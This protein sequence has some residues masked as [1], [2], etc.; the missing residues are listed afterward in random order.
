MWDD[1]KLDDHVQ[2]VHTTSASTPT[3]TGPV[4][5]AEPT[6]PTTACNTTTP[7]KDGETTPPNVPPPGTSIEVYWDEEKVWYPCIIKDAGPDTDG[8]WVSLC[9]YDD[10][11]KIWHN[12]QD[13]VHRLLTATVVRLEKLTCGTLRSILIKAGVSCSRLNKSSL[14]QT[15]CRSLTAPPTT[16][17]PDSPTE[18][19]TTPQP[20]SPTEETTTTP[21]PDS[22][23]DE[24]TTSPKPDTPNVPPPGTSIEVYWDEDEVWYPCI[25]KAA[26]TDTDGSWVSLCAYDDGAK[27]WHNLQ[28]H[29]HRS[30]TPT[31]TRVGKL[32][33]GELRR[34]L[35]QARVTFQ[36]E[37]RKA[38]LI[39]TLFEYLCQQHHDNAVDIGGATPATTDAVVV[40]GG[41]TPATTDAVVVTPAT[42]D[43][44]VVTGG[45]TP[46]STDVVV[47]TGG[48]TPATTD[49]VVVTGGA[50]R[51]TTTENVETVSELLHVRAKLGQTH[52]ARMKLQQNQREVDEAPVRQELP[53]E[54]TCAPNPYL[55]ATQTCQRIWEHAEALRV[56]TTRGDA[57]SY[58]ER[59]EYNFITIKQSDL[60]RWGSDHVWQRGDKDMTLLP[61]AIT[62]IRDVRGWECSNRLM[63]DDGIVFKRPSPH[64]PC[65]GSAAAPARRV[66]K[67][68]VDMSR[69]L[70]A[71]T[72]FLAYKSVPFVPLR[73][74]AQLKWGYK[75]PEQEHLE[76]KIKSRDQAR[77]EGRTVKW[78]KDLS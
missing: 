56:L 13:Q 69:W 37:T 67:W 26:G 60:K 34:S 70:H 2:Y 23:T 74:E 21:K 53:G 47:V 35:R 42:T 71:A 30:I 33:V 44:V 3:N 68:T 65:K 63:D 43:A 55:T 62:A 51:V 1:V 59:D 40:T 76:N 46:A 11:A 48:V 32:T 6:T 49:A 25:I 15:V 54:H 17:K 61:E 73:D 16:P 77:K 75:G 8:S 9:A 41:A 14:V 45:G 12:L 50:G 66:F 57:E 52:A 27:I 36:S 10:G 31:V 29:V 72:E 58:S 5:A 28:E 7:P 18:E 19:T 78:I 38:G 39:Q 4:D 22:P 24:E 64:L 20:D